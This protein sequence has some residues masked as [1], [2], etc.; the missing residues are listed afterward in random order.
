MVQQNQKDV[1][2]SFDSSGLEVGQALQVVHFEGEEALSTL[3]KFDITLI[4]ESP[5]LDLVKILHGTASLTIRSVSGT[6]QARYH[7]VLSSFAQREQ[8]SGHYVYQA[9]LVPRI[10]RLQLE[11]TTEV[12]IEDQPITKTLE[13][14]LKDHGFSY[15]DYRFAIKDASVYRNRSLVIQHQETTLDFM[16]RWL[17][18][19]GLYFHF[20]HPD[21]GPEQLQISDFKE[22][23]EPEKKRQAQ[24]IQTANLTP[25][26]LDDAVT[27]LN[28]RQKKL[29]KKVIV[30]DFNF[31]KASL[32]NGLKAE[33]SVDDANGHGE[34][35]IL[36]ENLRDEKEAQR[37]AKI[38]SELIQSESEVYDG[39]STAVGIRSGYRLV[40]EGHFRQS[41]NRTY[42]VSAVKHQGSQ[43]QAL[44][45]GLKDP[46]TGL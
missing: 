21:E 33:A 16:N 22:S 20:E 14:I 40:L 6:R 24:F 27:Q 7:G 26:L 44:Q 43:A 32:G 4:S 15:I 30:Q 9:V 34:V 3:F 8:L 2:F 23:L 5:D 29:P 46:W 19:E 28:C 36:G 31:R 13:T 11:K 17:E 42:T 37:M 1:R 45:I 41:F 18:K 12:Y 39:E 35:R 25:L 38:R 10:S